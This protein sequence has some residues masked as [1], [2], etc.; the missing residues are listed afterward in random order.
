M[1]GG[2]YSEIERVTS[3]GRSPIPDDAFLGQAQPFIARP[4]DCALR[5][6]DSCGIRSERPY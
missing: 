2:C 1:I 5:V 6:N 3:L 4:V